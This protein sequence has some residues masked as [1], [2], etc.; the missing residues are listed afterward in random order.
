MGQTTQMGR[1]GPT[2]W[3]DR[4]SE[5]ND[6]ANGPNNLDKPTEPYNS[7]ELGMPKNMN[8]SSGSNDLSKLGG[9]DNKSSLGGPDDLDG[10]NETTVRTSWAGSTTRSVGVG[11]MT[12]TG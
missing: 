3:I 11:P 7:N 6:G 8:K 4:G 2:T 1:V 12:W 10:P 5:Y 9:S